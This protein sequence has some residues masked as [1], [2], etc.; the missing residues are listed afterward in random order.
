MHNAKAIEERAHGAYKHQPSQ[1]I[2]N[3]GVFFPRFVNF[4][5][6]FFFAKN[7]L[8]RLLLGCCVYMYYII[9]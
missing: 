2:A 3:L 6:F 9:W 5:F 7:C 8:S 1:Q 4:K